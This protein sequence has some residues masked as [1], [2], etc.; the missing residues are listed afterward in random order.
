MT[1]ETAKLRECHVEGYSSLI[2]ET[3]TGWPQKASEE[4]TF[5]LSQEW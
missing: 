4:A 1:H 5:K 2:W 3:V